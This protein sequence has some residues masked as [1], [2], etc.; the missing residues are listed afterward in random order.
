LHKEAHLFSADNDRQLLYVMMTTRVSAGLTNYGHL[1]LNTTTPCLT[2]GLRGIAYFKIS[3]S[4]PAR[5][6]HSGGESDHLFSIKLD[7]GLT[8]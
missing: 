4:G 2:Y 7:R 5:D 3:V 1:G 8:P 6:L